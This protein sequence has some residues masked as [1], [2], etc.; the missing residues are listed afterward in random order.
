MKTFERKKYKQTKLAANSVTELYRT[1]QNEYEF[2][3]QRNC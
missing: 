1:A 3:R 2:N